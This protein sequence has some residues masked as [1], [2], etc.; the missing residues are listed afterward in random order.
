MFSKEFWDLVDE[1]MELGYINVQKH[2][3]YPLWIYN[4]TNECMF[5]GHWNEAT[6]QCR[7]LIVDE[8]KNAVA[9]PF[10]KFFNDTQLE[11][12]GIK[13]PN[14][15]FE[16]YDKLDGSL[17]ILYQIPTGE[18]RIATRGSF[19]SDQSVEANKILKEKYG[20]VIFNPNWTYLFEIIYPENRIVV[21]YGERR[22]LYL[23]AIIDKATG[24]DIPL[25]KSNE[26]PFPVV[27]RFDGVKDYKSA[28]EKF[29]DFSGT[30][31]EGLVVK[32]ESGFRV[33]LKTENYKLLH[34]I[35]CGL[36]ERR[37]WEIISE[38]GSFEDIIAIAPDEFHQWIRD[39]E[40]DLRMSY[41]GTEGVS[42]LLYESAL[43][44]AYEEI[45]A[46]ILRSDDKTLHRKKFA[47]YVLKCDNEIMRKVAF[48][49]YSNGNYKDIIW[50]HLRPVGNKT[51]RNVKDEE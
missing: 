15:P 20:Q 19:T 51:F 29:K 25:P 35:I 47:E 36:N 18:Y 13:I 8:N 11:G 30:E 32:F 34:K 9:L 43:E 28:I 21:N 45:G 26:V 46:E 27:L 2:P 22:D 14:Q 50:K 39:V 37:I 1:S 33:K 48:L 23:L 3:E 40:A 6:I 41:G 42:K 44:Y 10:K 4:Y 17:G 16:V 5:D 49:M 24:K 38:G 31:F 12:W 7:G